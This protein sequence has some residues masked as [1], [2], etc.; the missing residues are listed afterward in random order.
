MKPKFGNVTSHRT[1]SPSLTIPVKTRTPIEAFHMLRQGHPIDTMGAYY[2]EQGTLGSDFWMM[3]KTAKL[4]ALAYLKADNAQ[5]KSD[6]ESQL[7]EIEANQ[8]K[9]QQHD[10]EISN[11]KVTE[12]NNQ[13][14]QSS[15]GAIS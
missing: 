10:A 13:Q 7:A 9:Q 3:D 11:R 1:S 14:V 2:E 6:I 5:R 15:S 4:H 12:G 8:I